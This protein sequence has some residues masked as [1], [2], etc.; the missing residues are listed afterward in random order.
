MVLPNSGNSLSILQIATE[1]GGAVPHALSEYYGVASGIP[2]SGLIRI[3]DFYGKSNN[4]NP[5]TWQTGTTLA[6][7]TINSGT[8]TYNLAATSDSPIISYTITSSPGFGSLSSLLGDKTVNLSGTTP[9]TVGTFSWTISATDTET[10]STS[11]TF[12]MSTTSVG[13]TWISPDSLG[14]YNQNTNTSFNLYATSDSAIS[15]SLVSSPGF[16]YVSGSILYIYTQYV[17]TYTWIVRVTDQEGQTYD[18]ALQMTIMQPPVA[19]SWSAYSQPYLLGYYSRGDYVY[20]Q[21]TAQGNPTPTYQGIYM[22][23]LSVSSSGQVTGYIPYD[24]GG[25]QFYYFYIR[26]SNYLGSVD[27]E[28]RIWVNA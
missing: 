26:A 22:T 18:K 13:P 6:S 25:G 2:G 19:P 7:R 3:S 10:Q 15:Y 24:V 4:P 16:G 1:F 17:G 27:L 5:P 28:V 20:G 23:W 21:F 11:R 8:F 9:G 12:S 14:T